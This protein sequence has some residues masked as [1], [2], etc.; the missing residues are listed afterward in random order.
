MTERQLAGVLAPITT[1][2]DSATGEVAPVH[3][4]HNVTRLVA[5]GLD[6]VVVAG[7][8]GESA[9]LDPD[10]QR[11][12]VGWVREVLPDKR[13]LI[14]GT[15]GESTRQAV[16]LTRAAATEGADAVLV[17]P[18][19]YF[20]AAV[21]PASLADYYRA[22]ADASP[23][24]VLVYNIPKY[25]HLPIAAGLLRQLAAHTNIVGAKDS[26]GDAKNLA[27][28]RDAAPEWSVFVGSGSL[29]YAALELGCDGGILAVACFAAPLCAQ[30][31]AAFRAGD[32]EGA[33]KLQEIG[34]AHV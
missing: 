23:V 2:F 29:L 5:A 6:G 33:G 27:A 16:A 19:A 14:A 15:G 7:S 1:P 11:R 22:V 4:R 30:V 9:L 18:P 34:R 10:E 20:S 3:L 31:F 32:R 8:T 12:M 21:S 25:T 26:S 24:P 28:Y 13:W 17:R